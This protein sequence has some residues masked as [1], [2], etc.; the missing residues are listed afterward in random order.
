[1]AT[2]CL[3]LSS[4]EASA[5]A[6]YDLGGALEGLGA[7]APFLIVGLRFAVA[8]AGI[9]PS[10]PILLAAGATEG[11]F[12]GSVYVLVGAQLGAAVGF[13]AGR[14]FGSDY[15]QRK[16]WLDRFAKSRPGAWFFTGDSSQARLMTAVFYCRL[17]PGLNFDA[18]SYVAGV[19]P[20][21]FGRFVVATFAGLLP[22]TLVLVAIG[23]QLIAFGTLEFVVVLVALTVASVTPAL[24]QVGQRQAQDG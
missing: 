6:G 24:L 5:Y 11:V 23:Q 7:W 22:Y 8:L 15:I 18:L 16:G 12:L 9:V 21:T 14:Q 10:S 13:L 3:F 1:M 2:F 17:I 19:T 4:S 20:L